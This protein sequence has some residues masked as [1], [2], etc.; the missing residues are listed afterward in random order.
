MSTTTIVCEILA[1]HAKLTRAL[2]D[3]ANIAARSVGQA[4]L[5]KTHA[6][7]IGGRDDVVITLHLP[8]V[9]AAEQHQVWCLACRLACLC[10]QARVSV[11]ILGQD[12]FASPPSRP[13]RRQSA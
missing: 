11:L 2:A 12:A 6:V 7:N 8:T 1:P 3:A 13:H 5:I 4:I 10:P 9:L